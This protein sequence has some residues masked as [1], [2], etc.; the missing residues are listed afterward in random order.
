VFD[1][2]EVDVLVSTM[3]AMINT[4]HNK[5]DLGKDCSMDTVS[6]QL[7]YDDC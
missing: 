4:T 3:E 5:E 1:S 7:S 6:H 2:L